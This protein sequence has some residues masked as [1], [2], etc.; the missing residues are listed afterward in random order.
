MLKKGQVTIFIIIAILVIAGVILF[1]MFK[2]KIKTNAIP[3]D[4]EGVHQKVEECLEF[5]SQE[6][7]LHIGQHGGYYEPDDSIAVNYFGENIPYYYLDNEKH[8]PEKEI[9]EEELNNY[10]EDK[11]GNCLDFENFISQG[12]DINSGGLEVETMVEEDYVELNM[13][14]DLTV[15]K[16]EET[17]LFE[18]FE[19]DIYF[20]VIELLDSS[21]EIIDNY[22]EEPGIVCVSCLNEIAIERE[23]KMNSNFFNN[24]TILTIFFEKEE[25]P[26]EWR[27]AM[28]P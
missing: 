26:L 17:H 22:S 9:I 16:G 24:N 11:I 27:F 21:K 28:G 7:I 8:I 15:S 13:K 3:S 25:N 14:Y 12:L 19:Q 5:T 23:L 10:I 4:F 20:N 6:A 1:F 18:E 2:D